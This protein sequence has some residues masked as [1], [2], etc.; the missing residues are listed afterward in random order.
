MDTRTIYITSTHTYSGKSALCIGLLR[1][2]KSKG[3]KVGY[4]KPVSTTP[5]VVNDQ[6][7]DEDSRF[8]KA[9]LDLSDAP[10]ILTP[11]LLTDQKVKQIIS[12]GEEDGDAAARVK[13]AFETLCAGKDVVVLEGGASLREG[14]IVNLS[15]PQVS[16]LLGVPELVVVPYITDLQLVDD[17][18][19]A[20]I[21]LGSS[22][23]GAVINRVPPHKMDLVKD[24][25][26]PFVS[27][28][29][30]K[31]FAILPRKR[32]LYAASV[33][34]IKDGLAGEV[35]CAQDHMDELVEHLMVGA[36]GVE[37]ALTYFRR[38][39]NKAV[40]TGGDRPD[41]QIAALETSTKCL[42]LTGNLRPNPMIIGRA[43]EAG[44]P[45]ILTRH[46]TMTAVEIIE[47]FFGKTRFQQER[48]IQR[49]EALLEE[50][51][52]FDA[53]EAAINL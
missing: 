1:R 31:V 18:I 26:V 4:M 50:T 24:R 33:Q 45:I 22:L 35:L 53:L 25:V 21:R 28:K 9:H 10:D 27:G 47:T 41:I 52:D 16:E 3:M 37:S 8:A 17:L 14:W 49:F 30:V 36:M 15:P 29:G 12:G 40:I 44:V 5:T 48:K 11:V 34:E 38:K 6:V 42:I 13:K 20:R 46:D 2:F 32:I 23:L 51:M 43:E 7:V 19:T 39:A